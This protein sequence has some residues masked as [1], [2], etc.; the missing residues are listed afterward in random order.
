MG[1][2]LTATAG[3]GKATQ[4]PGAICVLPRRPGVPTLRCG[5]RPKTLAGAAHA[6]PDS[7]QHLQ[8]ASR[9]S[10]RFPSGR[11]AVSLCCLLP[12]LLS[13]AAAAEPAD[14]LVVC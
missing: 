14:V 4:R 13:A 1:Y 10:F 3:A 6:M 8:P 12:A 5:E 7:R 2:K 11:W 9:Q